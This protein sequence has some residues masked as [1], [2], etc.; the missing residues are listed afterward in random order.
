MSTDPPL[1]PDSYVSLDHPMANGHT[2]IKALVVLAGVTLLAEI[3]LAFPDNTR[4][5][6]A[7]CDSCHVSPTGG[8]VLN[9]YGRGTSSAFLSTLSSEERAKAFYGLSTPTWLAIGGDQRITRLGVQSPYGALYKTI[10]MQ[11]DLELALTVGQITAAATWGVYGE[12]LEEGSRRHYVL[13]RLGDHF[14]VRAGRFYAGYGLHTADHTAYS[15]RELGFDEGQETVNFEV[16]TKGS[17]GDL[18]VT[19]VYGEAAAFAADPD[20]GYDTDTEGEA[21]VAARLQGYVGK[22]SLVGMSAIHLASYDSQKT[23]YG[24]HYVLT[25]FSW[26]YAMGDWSYFVQEKG[27]AGTSSVTVEPY[28]GVL[29]SAVSEA[30]GT[31]IDRTQRLGL[32]LQ[33]FPFPHWEVS[34]TAR[35]EETPIGAVY[36]LIGMLHHYL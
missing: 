6:Y 19:S 16:G 8:G 4:H 25:A 27:Y 12:G 18:T 33:L 26:L 1:E 36:S 28:R 34:Y 10:P 14:H 17:V 24:F 22:A 11:A 2:I 3:A 21:G 7:S 15:R 29:V 30:K 13:L 35:R 20:R 5:G 31:A 32:S 23:R 9:A